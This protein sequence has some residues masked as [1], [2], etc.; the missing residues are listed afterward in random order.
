M[1]STA[2]K[3]IHGEFKVTHHATPYGRGMSLVVG[4]VTSGVPMLRLHSSCLFSESFHSNE[5]D[6]ALQLSKALQL[7]QEKSPGL[8]I[9][10]FEEG[11]GAG[12]EKKMEAINLEKERE[13]DTAEAFKVLGLPADPRDYRNALAILEELGVSRQ[14]SLITNNPNKK[15]VLEDNGFEVV[16]IEK[17]KLELNYATKKYLE[18]KK[19]VLGHSLIDLEN[20]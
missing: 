15:E 11:R 5:C 13:I 19:K 17:L 12:L 9:Y 14:V 1:I 2:L 6:C 10:L 7:I 4:D 16:K 3:T 8:V 18:M 20:E